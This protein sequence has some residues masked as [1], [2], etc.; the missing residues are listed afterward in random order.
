MQALGF[1]SSVRVLYSPL[2]PDCPGSS[3]FSLLCW[4]PQSGVAP[5]PQFCCSHLSGLNLSSL[6][7]RTEGYFIICSP[8]LWVA[9]HVLSTVFHPWHNQGGVLRDL[10]PLPPERPPVVS[11]F[12]LC[13]SSGCRDR[14]G[15]ELPFPNPQ[16]WT[17][18]L[19]LSFRCW[20]PWDVLGMK[21]SFESL[22]GELLA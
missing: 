22:P 11:F 13:T 16:S 6:P 14:D 18:A 5:A 9:A 4:A 10:K 1:N 12:Y 17:G 21:H 8:P 19:A 7:R 2:P 20:G 3:K 15:G